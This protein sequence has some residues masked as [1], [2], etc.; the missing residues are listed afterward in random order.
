MNKKVSL[1]L[2]MSFMVA[3]CSSVE[4]AT[5][6]PR[7]SN[8]PLWQVKVKKSEGFVAP[9]FKV[10]INDS[11]VIDE[12]A[13]GWTGELDANG[14][15]RGHLVTITVR[16]VEQM[17]NYGSGIVSDEGPYYTTVTIDNELVGQW[18]F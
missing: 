6:R 18:K 8:D 17:H 15:Y 3:A 9:D 5:Y 13:S 10:L 11:T 14:N 12:G 4:Y 2:L 7:G 16:H 1:L